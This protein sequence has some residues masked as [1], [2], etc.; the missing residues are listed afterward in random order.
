[1]AE[2]TEQLYISRI[3]VPEPPVFSG[4]PLEYAAG[5][6]AFEILIENK[7]IPPTEKIHYLKRY[8]TGK[9]RECV[10]GLFLF[11]TEEA[12]REAKVLLKAVL[13]IRVRLQTL[14]ESAS[15]NGL[16]FPHEMDRHSKVT[17]IFF[18]SV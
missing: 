17:L 7:R 11:S 5:K 4:S 18:D 9:A 15:I 12:Y 8:L 14:S 16:R 6:S 2:L 13:E 10:E 1:M 3:P